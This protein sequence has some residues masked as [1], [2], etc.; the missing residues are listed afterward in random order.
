MKMYET[1]IIRETD[2]AF[3]LGCRK[4]YD[5]YFSNRSSVF[6]AIA[7]FDSRE[8]CTHLFQAIVEAKS[9]G[10]EVFELSKYLKQHVPVQD[11]LKSNDIPSA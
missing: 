2:D 9:A 6:F 1:F 7:I 5:A 8:Q 11:A 4:S 3:Q 10:D